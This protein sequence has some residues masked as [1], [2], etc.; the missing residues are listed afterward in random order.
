MTPRACA[1]E[2]GRRATVTRAMP[3]FVSYLLVS[4][5]RRPPVTRQVAT[6]AHVSRARS[7]KMKKVISLGIEPRSPRPQRGILTTKL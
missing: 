3:S 4:L 2:A 7:C 5:A 1:A 6:H